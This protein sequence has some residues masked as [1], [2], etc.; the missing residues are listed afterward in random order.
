MTLQ[1]GH[2]G[3]A[4]PLTIKRETETTATIE[5][6]IKCR[7]TMYRSIFESKN[8][9]YTVFSTASPIIITISCSSSSSSSSSRNNNNKSRKEA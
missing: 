4:D 1:I 9:K 7:M 2:I 8:I 6:E 3:L 5:M